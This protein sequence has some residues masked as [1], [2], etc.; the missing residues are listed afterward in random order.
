MFKGVAQIIDGLLHGKWSEVWTGIK[1]VVGGAVDFMKSI[2]RQ[3]VKTFL[4]LGKKIGGA[5]KDGIVAGLKGLGKLLF[6]IIA[7][8]IN[9]IIDAINAIK[10][11]GFNP[12]GPGKI[13]GVDPIPGN[14]PRLTLGGAATI[15]HVVTN[16]D[17]KK[18]SE[19]VTKH[20][21]RAKR[22][23]APQRTGRYAGT[24][25]LVQG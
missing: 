12:P 16:L 5:F 4:F 17:G 1:N 25:F 15:V 2:L 6:K 22:K 8:P 20:Q 11:P 19:S 7:A 10:I 13:P 14:I 24:S 9:T 3:A 23:T 18:V 21:D